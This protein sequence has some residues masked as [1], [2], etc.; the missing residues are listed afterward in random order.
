MER[1]L[2][3]EFDVVGDFFIEEDEERTAKKQRGDKITNNFVFQPNIQM[4]RAV[5]SIDWSPKVSELL[6]VSYSKC[7]EYRFDEPDGLVNIFSLNLKT[8]P[9]ITLTC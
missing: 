7:N 5:T 9:E 4:K 3:A 8:R 2:D 1:A 6:L